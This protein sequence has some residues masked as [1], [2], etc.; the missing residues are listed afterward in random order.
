M[1]HF[2]ENTSGKTVFFLQ[3]YMHARVFSF[4]QMF[5]HLLNTQ[6]YEE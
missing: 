4:T 5:E 6:N 3:I 2:K 1:K